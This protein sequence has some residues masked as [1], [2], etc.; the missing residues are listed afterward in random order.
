M[1]TRKI[2]TQAEF[3]KMTKTEQ[4]KWVAW[5]NKKMDKIPDVDPILPLKSKKSTAKKKSK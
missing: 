4:Q 3:N 5:A 2:P 1:A